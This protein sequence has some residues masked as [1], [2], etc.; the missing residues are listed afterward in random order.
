[1]RPFGSLRAR[2][3]VSV[4]AAFAIW[5]FLVCAG[6]MAYTNRTA[7]RT[8]D[9]LLRASADSFR[10]DLGE[11]SSP[12]GEDQ[13]RSGP[14]VQASLAA[15]V[16]EHRAYLEANHLAL[17]IEDAQGRILERSAQSSPP[18]SAVSDN[19]WRV[20][21]V[22][23]QHYTL[24]LGYDWSRVEVAHSQQALVLFALSLC[25]LFAAA[26]G[27]WVLV[28]RSLSPLSRLSRQAREASTETL[29]LRL[30]APSQ[31]AEM[32]EL[33]STL[34]D[35]LSRL[36]QT[37]AAKGRFYA[38]AS[39]ELRTPLQALSGHLEVARSRPRSAEEY[40]ATLEEAHR[41]TRRLI[42]L[43]QGLL[44]LGQLEAATKPPAQEPVSLADV[45]RRTLRPLQPLLASRGLQL[46][47]SLEPEGEIL[48]PPSHAEILLRNLLE[49]AAHYTT[50]GG[51]MR[52]TVEER[53]DAVLVEVFNTCP[54]P[55][56]WDPAAL[57]EPFY[58]LDASRNAR[59]GGSGLGLSICKAL[60]GA[61]GWNLELSYDRTGVL[62][63]LTVPRQVSELSPRA[64]G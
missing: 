16:T 47:T 23:T 46:E 53:P 63:R 28:G 1:M 12:E 31:D 22:P 34:N 32:V 36:G 62:A 21:K 9:L 43:T 64:Q 59:T 11:V 33:V 29:H 56:N 51:A 10:N 19:E 17:W 37:A 3:T 39:H 7:Q 48:A 15:F 52:V 50:P 55:A 54:L 60:A 45:C 44:F 13:T 25:A 49:N 42:A 18:G 5:L 26:L 24:V 2:L 38:A 35:L 27:A 58:R 20:L 40:Q 41:Q 8:A 6:L 61:N 14:P 30:E 57:F 4:T